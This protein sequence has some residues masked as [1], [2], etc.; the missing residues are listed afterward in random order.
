M[1]RL[2]V[3]RFKN[4]KIQMMEMH[5]CLVRLHLFLWAQLKKRG[6]IGPTLAMTCV[7]MMLRYSWSSQE[8]K[9]FHL[10][11]L[12]TWSK[13]Q[14]ACSQVRIVGLLLPERTVKILEETKIEIGY[15]SATYII[16]M[17][18]LTK[19]LME[20]LTGETQEKKWIGDMFSSGKIPRYSKMICQSQW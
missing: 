18:L 4:A 7:M 14:A 8:V 19:T 1:K 11:K 12:R 17:E 16:K 2:Q 3:S 10:K 6:T 20:K 5:L 15:R 13:R 9:C